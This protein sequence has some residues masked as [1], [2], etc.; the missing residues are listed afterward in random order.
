[1]NLTE[2]SL[3]ALHPLRILEPLFRVQRDGRLIASL[4]RR[5]D[6]LG[7]QEAMWQPTLRRDLLQLK[8]GGRLHAPRAEAFIARRRLQRK[9]SNIEYSTSIYLY[10]HHQLLFLPLVKTALPHIRFGR[11]GQAVRDRWWSNH[12]DH[13]EATSD[14]VIALSALEPIYY[15]KVVGTLSLSTLDEFGRYDAWRKR[16][17]VRKM[18]TWLDVT[19]DWIKEESGRLLDE[20]DRLDP[21]GE[22]GKVVR[23]GHPGKWGHAKGGCPPC[24]RPPRRRRAP[25]RLPRRTGPQAAGET[26][27]R[28]SPDLGWEVRHALEASTRARSP[29]HRLRAFASPAAGAG[30]RGR[31]GADDL[32]PGNEPIRH[33][34]RPRLH[35]RSR[36][37]GRRNGSRS[38]GRVCDR[39][40]H[41]GREQWQVLE[42]DAA[43]HANPRGPRS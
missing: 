4:A 19:P 21:L 5:D 17:G 16:L 38:P 18:L 25:P 6:T 22:W 1:M 43:S 28:R 34:Y 32:P 39:P 31:Y 7:W 27:R 37:S 10:S 11:N 8:E 41:R 24:D 13:A 33:S 14:L 30:P 9:T 15:R 26:P 23:A 2:G 12:I 40:I 29:T 35:R 20:A 3:E 42:A 36:C